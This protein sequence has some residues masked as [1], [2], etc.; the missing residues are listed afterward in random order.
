M[1]RLASSLFRPRRVAFSRSAG[2]LFLFYFSLTITQMTAA[3][4]TLDHTIGQIHFDA[5]TLSL[6]LSQPST[7]MSFSIADSS[8]ENRRLLQVR[9][10]SDEESKLSP[11][12]YVRGTDLIASYDGTAH[13]HLSPQMYWRAMDRQR[14]FG[15]ELIVSVQTSLLDYRQPFYIQSTGLKNTRPLECEQSGKEI[16]NAALG[17]LATEIEYLEIVHPTD[18]CSSTIKNNS[19]EWQIIDHRLEKGVI[20]RARMQ[21]WWIRGDNVLNTAN[22]LYDEFSSSEPPL[23]V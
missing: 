20:R 12:P 15:V 9:G 4:W 19:T 14:A 8:L 7:G 23:T 11:A 13:S 3:L 1:Q 2:F 16:H 21:A 22:A 17:S 6:D 5:S 18:F 10:I